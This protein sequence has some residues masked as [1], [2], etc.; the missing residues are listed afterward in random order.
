ATLHARAFNRLEDMETLPDGTVLMAETGTGHILALSD[1]NDTPSVKSYLH[2]PEIRHP[3]NL[4]WD[5]QRHWLWI[6]DDDSPS[7]LWAWSGNQLI[8]IASHKKAE[9]TGV[10]ADG[11]VVYINLQQ[12]GNGAEL[13]LK[14]TELP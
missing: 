8:Q 1:K 13:T 6:T 2:R 14:L 4:A 5:N 10:L 9:I 7:R 3:D 12:K 11:D